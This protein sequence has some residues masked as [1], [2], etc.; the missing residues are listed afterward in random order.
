MC[1]LLNVG[2]LV[3][4]LVAWILPLVNI[5]RRDKDNNKSWP[6]L[7]IASLNACTVSLW[8]QII[9]N[10]HLIKNEDWS[11]LMDITEAVVRVS[12]ILVVVTVV[13]NFYT[14]VIYSKK[15]R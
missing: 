13:L 5:I 14:V 15:N 12:L 7:S 10:D 8:F 3:L 2:S 9:Y 11:A 6:W 1:V 4:G